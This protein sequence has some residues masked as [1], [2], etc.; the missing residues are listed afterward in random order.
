ME[1]EILKTKQIGY[2]ML[3]EFQLNNCI[4][5]GHNLVFEYKESDIKEYRR[6][7]KVEAE[8]SVELVIQIKPIN[9]V[10][11]RGYLQ[12]INSTHIECTAIIDEILD[13]DS[14]LCEI[15]GLGRVRVELEHHNKELE[16]GML[17]EF[18][19]SLEVVYAL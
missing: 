1:I 2:D 3:V 6:A 19:G 8:L 15:E 7:L 18:V 4:L 11:S 17:V 5:W 12:N 16:V 14:F 13:T 10:K 9:Q